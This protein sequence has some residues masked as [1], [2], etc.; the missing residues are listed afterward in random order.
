M[1]A[2]LSAVLGDLT[3]R[4]ISSIVD[5]YQVRAATN[6]NNDISRLQQL[7]LRASTVDMEAEGRRVTNPAMLL[8]LRQLREAMYRG[9]FVMDTAIVGIPRARPKRRETASNNYNLQDNMD[10]LEA[11]LDGMKEFLLIL[12][13]CPRIVRQPYSAYMFMERCMFGRHAEKERIVNFL[14]R[15]C[16][17][18][19]LDVLPVVGVHNVGKRTLVEHACREEKVQRKNF[20][21]IL[22]F[23]SVDLHDLARNRRKLDFPGGKCLIIAEL[24]HDTDVVAW[25]EIQHSLRHRAGGV[26]I[27][28]IL[29]SRMD[30]QVSSLGTE[31]ALRLSALH[32]EEYWYFFRV[33]A[34]GSANPYDHHPGLASVAKEIVTESAGS[35]MM[36]SM[37][38]GVLRANMNIQFWRRVLWSI[39]KSIHVHRLFFGGD[40]RD[41]PC[42]GKKCLS[43]FHSSRPDGPVFFCYNRYKTR[44]LVQG[45]LSSVINLEDL[46]NGRAVKCGEKIDVILQSRIPPFYA[47]ISQ[48]VVKKP[49]EGVDLGNKVHK[50]KRNREKSSSP[51]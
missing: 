19:S 37:L 7:L 42:S 9:F 16:S 14:L 39:R 44:S 31:E 22:R 25:S 8:Q 29:T 45:G 47:Y 4:F 23:S 2:V 43:Y 3:S 46:L 27:K 26:K 49:A 50:R 51:P 18:S 24:V 10:S 32:E 11:K 33:L 1:D 6:A 15:P 17:S 12:M 34:F 40:P 38:C 41:D 5:K 48:C 13:H 36:G 30:R 21:H 35:F 20:P 28:V